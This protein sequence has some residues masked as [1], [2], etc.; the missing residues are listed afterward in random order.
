MAL[1]PLLLAV[2]GQLNFHPGCEASVGRHERRHVHSQTF[3]S[4]LVCKHTSQHIEVPGRVPHSVD[5]ASSQLPSEGCEWT[6]APNLQ[7]HAPSAYGGGR[8]TASS[9]L[10]P[11]P[12]GP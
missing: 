11:S 6:K 3:L 1:L 12:G 10:W 4:D 9:T 8:S 5:I 7:L 2:E